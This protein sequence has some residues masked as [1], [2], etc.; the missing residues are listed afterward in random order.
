MMVSTRGSV[1]RLIAWQWRGVVLFASCAVAI[2][3][4]HFYVWPN[5]KIPQLPLGIVGGALGIF[6]SF[7]TNSS[8]ARWWE[9]RQLWGRLVNASRTF[10]SQA[11]AY[12][13]QDGEGRELAIAMVRRHVGY[14]HALRAALRQEDVLA[15]ADV[16][17][18]M[19]EA[20]RRALAKESN[21]NHAICHENVE[22][23]GLAVRRGWIDTN[24]LLALDETLR[25][26]LDVQGGCE[27]IKKT[28]LPR[29]YAFIAERLVWAFGALFPLATVHEL[30]W[31]V[32]PV[33]VIVCLAFSL[34]SE[35]G[36]VLEDPFTLFWNGL[37]LMALSR[38]IEVNLRQRLGD[39]DLPPIPGPDASGVLM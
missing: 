2:A 28:P 34:I 22:A 19:P 15:D 24:Q 9:G 10:S 23:V 12:L 6:V 32:V 14:V 30:G 4:L 21:V 37:P 8:Y 1:L 20:E 39:T 3:L 25:A 35:A 31:Y 36:R 27:R 7:R 11:L 17:R 38:T 13:P 18:T 29:G 5:A 33:N 26:F 16:V